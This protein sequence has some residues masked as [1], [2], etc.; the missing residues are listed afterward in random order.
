MRNP[1]LWK[2]LQAHAFD[3]QG[4]APYSVKLARTQGWSRPFTLRVIEEYRR[5]LYLTQVS[6]R[7]VTPSQTVDAAWH[8]HLTYTRDYWEDFCP[9]VVGRP[10][11]H[12]PCAGD[13]EMPRYRDQFAAT[14]ALYEAEF[15]GEP[16]SDIWGGEDATKR[17]PR[18]Q[19]LRD[20]TGGIDGGLIFIAIAGCL[21]LWLM[22]PEIHWA[23]YVVIMVAAFALSALLAR[24]NGKRKRRDN[25][26]NDGGGYPGASGDDTSG[27]G[28]SHNSNDKHSSG[29]GFWGTLFDGDGDSGS[30]G[31]GCGGC[32]D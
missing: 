21:V 19:L 14:K 4:S 22:R 23:V 31:G 20:E 1:E 11:H 29:R 28:R 16:P 12:Q 3:G 6:S 15:G 13:E 27:S 5:F 7:Q 18:R 8:L 2:R 30:D 32:G 25:Q 9:K 24:P 10:I 26:G 17:R